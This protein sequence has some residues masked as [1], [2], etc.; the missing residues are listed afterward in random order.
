LYYFSRYFPY[1]FTIRV[2]AKRHQNGAREVSEL[3][4]KGGYTKKPEGKTT[5]GMLSGQLDMIFKAVA[6]DT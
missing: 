2:H 5:M 1:D 6:Q 4:Q 3:L